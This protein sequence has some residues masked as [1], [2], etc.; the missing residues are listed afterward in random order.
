MDV[1]EIIKSR[2]SIFKFKAEPVTRAIVDRILEAGIWAPNH[3]L[4]EPWR[5]IVLGPRAK[6]ILARRYAEIQS[7]KASAGASPESREALRR[8]GYA[9]FMSKPTIISIVC[10]RDGD[11]VKQREDYAAACCAAQNIQLVAWAQGVGMQWSTG[12]ITLEEAT[13]S[14]LDV[15][16]ESEYIIGFFYTGY[17]EEVPEPRRKPLTEVLRWTD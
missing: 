12:P 9:K 13:F 16:F 8:A 6:E 2:R 7:A 15:N 14:L 1:M 17:P 10:R 4:T 11:E 5:F 3:H